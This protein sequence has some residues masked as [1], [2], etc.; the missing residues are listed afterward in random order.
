MSTA[1]RSGYR[2]LFP[3]LFMVIAFYSQAGGIMLDSTRIIYAQDA[4]QRNI[5]IRNTS[6]DTTFLVQAWIEDAAGRRSSD[7]IATPPLFTSGPG[8]ENILRLMYTGQQLPR[9]RETL[10]YFNVKGVPSVN[11]KRLKVITHL[12]SQR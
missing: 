9:D 1:S 2:R 7:F 12:S 3:L 10:Y 8:N 11:K 6:T 4:K 5:S